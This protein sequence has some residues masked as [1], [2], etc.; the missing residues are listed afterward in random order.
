[1]RSVGAG[2]SRGA[3][4]RRNTSSGRHWVVPWVRRPAVVEHHV[5]A[6]RW[7][8]ARS[9]NSSPAK[10]EPRTYWTWRSTL[11]LSFGERTRAGSITKPLDWAY[12]KKASLNR[13][14]TS[15]ALVT[16][17]AMLSGTT[18]AKTP[19]K[20]AHA[21]SKP[22]MTASVVWRWLSHTKQCRE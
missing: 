8:S 10:N 9:T 7:A 6:R 14:S 4:S 22:S 18:T 17:A 5:V 21:A 20:N 16:M 19:P 11:G 13:G 12:S 15:S 2:Q 1:M 3:S